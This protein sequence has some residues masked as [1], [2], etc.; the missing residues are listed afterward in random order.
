MTA[1][2]YKAPGTTFFIPG[3]GRLNFR[4]RAGHYGAWAASNLRDNSWFQVNFGRFVK[5]TIVSTQGRDDAYQWV[6]KYRLTYSYDGMF[7]RNYLE[8]GSVKVIFFL[9]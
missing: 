5:V 7:L 3:N 1:S 8:D 2:S 9:I 4:R 6:K